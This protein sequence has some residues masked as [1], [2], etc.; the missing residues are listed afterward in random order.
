MADTINYG[1]KGAG[2]DLQL[3]K[4]N[5][6][7]KVSG[8]LVQFRNAADDAYVNVEVLDPT[9]DQHAA[10]K[11][12]VDA[13][14]SGLDLKGSVRVATQAN[15]TFVAGG[16]GVGATLTSLTTGVGENDI[17]GVTLV[18]GE[19]VLVKEESVGADNG[20]YEVTQ[21]ADGAS[22]DAILTRATDA[23]E[24]AEVTSGMFTF[25]E[26]GTSAGQGW[27][28]TTVNPITVDSTALVFT[29]FSESGTQDPLFRQETF[30]FGDTGTNAFAVALPT[31]AIVQRVKVDVTGAWDDEATIVINDAGGETYMSA[32]E[33]DPE[34]AS[35]FVAD[36]LGQNQIGADAL[37]AVITDVGTPGAGTAVVHVDYVLA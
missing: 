34:V 31:N 35:V 16:S 25:V 37:Q 10:T 32:A 9:T 6:R 5:P 1:L 22:A 2:S 7:V 29:Q 27:V 33:N 26:E 3:G 30:V 28:I 15:S 17:D 20:I 36:L 14:A 23:D 19:R 18:V 4:K 12:Y 13:V 11:G 24:D 21:V 8:G